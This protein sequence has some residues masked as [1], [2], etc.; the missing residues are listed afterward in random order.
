[1]RV[2]FGFVVANSICLGWLCHQSASPLVL[3][4]M[5]VNVAAIAINGGSV[6]EGLARSTGAAG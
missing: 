5:A 3:V 1:M 4:A 6:L 2:S